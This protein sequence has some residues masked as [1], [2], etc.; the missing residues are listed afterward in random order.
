MYMNVLTAISACGSP[1][2]RYRVRADLRGRRIPSCSVAMVIALS[3]MLIGLALVTFASVQAPFHRLF[4]QLNGAHLWVDL[5][6]QNPQTQTHLDAVT[7][8]PN[9]VGY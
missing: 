1:A 2:I 3:T 5:D 9:V 8:M 7:H 4:T 6:P